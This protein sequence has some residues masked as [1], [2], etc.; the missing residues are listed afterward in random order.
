[1]GRIIRRV[2]SLLS[3]V[4]VISLG[5]L[6]PVPSSGLPEHSAGRVIVLCL[7]LLRTRFT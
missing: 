3:E 6:L 1:M 7:A 5:A 2:L 4:T